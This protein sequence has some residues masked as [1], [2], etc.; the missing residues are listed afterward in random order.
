GPTPGSPRGAPRCA[1]D[2][3]IRLHP[4]S[5]DLSLAHVRTVQDDGHIHV[6]ARL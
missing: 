1:C 5:G 2:A 4:I 6:L 3:L